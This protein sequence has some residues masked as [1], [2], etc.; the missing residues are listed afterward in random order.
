M[1]RRLRSRVN[2]NQAI[3]VISNCVAVE[4][5]SQCASTHVRDAIALV[6]TLCA[7]ITMKQIDLERERGGGGG[8]GREDNLQMHE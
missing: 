6:H 1:R 8:R 2:A 5:H 4:L 7:P 3:Y